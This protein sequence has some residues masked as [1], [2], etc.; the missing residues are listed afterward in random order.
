MSSGAVATV[1]LMETQI[2]VRGTGQSR[3]LPDRAVLRVT[4]DG[5]SGD[6][7]AAYQTVTPLARQ[8]DEVVAS[9]GE[10]VDRA[11][12]GTLVVQPKT[13]WR[14]GETVRT[15]WKASRTSVVEVKDFSRLGHLVAELVGAGGEIHGPYW[16]LD[17][18]NDA[19]AE[20]RR[21]AAEDARRRADVYAGALGLRVESIAWVA[22]PGLRIGQSQH[23]A[24]AR[25]M[26]FAAEATRG[27]AADEVIDI[28]PDEMTVEAAIE[29]GFAFSAP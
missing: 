3:T 21:L 14:R 25:G 12:T 15:G 20:A 5:E 1:C 7:D 11:M 27:G 18:T 16:Q 22:E 13:R 24:V 2:I 4:V 17:P 9:Y 29:V 23:Q 19:H 8:V 28:S 10:A 6:R 26:A